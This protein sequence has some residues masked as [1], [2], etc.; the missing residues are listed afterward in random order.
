VPEKSDRV[1]RLSRSERSQ[2]PTAI[3]RDAIRLDMGEPDFPTPGHIQEA[4]VRAMR[5]NLTHYGNAYGEPALREAICLSLR[6]DFGVERKPENALVTSGGI[7]AINVIS[8]TY[9][10]PGDEALI[11]DPEYSAYADSVSL[12]GGTPVFVPLR[13]DFHIDFGA[14][15]KCVSPKTKLVFISNPGNPTGRV[16][17]EAEISSLARLAAK[18]DLLLVLDEAYHKLIYSGVRFLS[19]CQV[20]ESRSRCILLNSFSKTYAM[21]GWRVG[22][23][24]AD[25]PLIKDMVTFHKATII[26]PN[27]PAQMACAAAAAGSQECVEAMRQEYEK[28]RDLVAKKLKEIKGLDTPPCEGAFYFFPRFEHALTSQQMTEHLFNKGILVR[29]GTEFGAGGQKH[30]RISFSTSRET[31]ELGM[32]RLKQALDELK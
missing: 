18:H 2:R 5:D 1:T 15:E 8:A 27:V 31:L 9:L 26:C 28:R 11:A 12:F 13:A 22:Y 6:R 19:I 32:D 23:M 25:A 4:A 21:T 10:N 30:F 16:L 24:V 7:E 17:R 20:E 29:S 3:P 14:M